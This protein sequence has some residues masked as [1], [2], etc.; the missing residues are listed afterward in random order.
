[1]F[2]AVFFCVAHLLQKRRGAC[3]TVCLSTGPIV[4][5]SANSYSL[6]QWF[7]TWGSRPLWESRAFSGGVANWAF[8]ALELRLPETSADTFITI[9]RRNSW[10]GVV[11]LYWIV[12]MGRGTK[13]VE[14]H[15]IKGM[16]K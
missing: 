3:N 4:E 16:D 13:N 12:V 1:V 6:K 9:G 15:C 10:V 8:Q 14:K 2:V 5:F 7:S 11:R